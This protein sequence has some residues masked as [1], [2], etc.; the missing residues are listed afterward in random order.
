MIDMSIS[1]AI[2]SDSFQIPEILTVFEYSIILK[3]SDDI[4]LHLFR[5]TEKSRIISVIAQ[6][7]T[8]HIENP[9]SIKLKERPRISGLYNCCK[10]DC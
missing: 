1:T 3:I 5:G 6:Q 9:S 10:R 4:Q 8:S 7:A 2:R